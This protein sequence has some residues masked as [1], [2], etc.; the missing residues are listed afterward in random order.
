MFVDGLWVLGACVFDYCF[1]LIV[2][3]GFDRFLLLLFVGMKYGYVFYLVCYV[4]LCGFELCF[5]L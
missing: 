3:V 1:V 4:V 5:T 2:M